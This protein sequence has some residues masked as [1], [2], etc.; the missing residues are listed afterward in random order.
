MKAACLRGGRVVFPRG[1][2]VAPAEFVIIK[3]HFFSHGFQLNLHFL[4]RMPVSSV[5]RLHRCKPTVYSPSPAHQQLQELYTQVSQVRLHF[6]H[7]CSPALLVLRLNSF[8]II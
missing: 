5:F 3:V 6:S 4:M 2:L 1:S 7:G 8:A